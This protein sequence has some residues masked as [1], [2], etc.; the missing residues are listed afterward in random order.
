[1]VSVFPFTGL[2]EEEEVAAEEQTQ[3]ELPLFR[4]YA[5][6]FEKN[7]FYYKDGNPILLEGLDALQIW[8]YKTLKTERF[9]YLAYSW[10][11]GIELEDT[12]LT[13][14]TSTGVDNAE[15]ERYVREALLVN[16]YIT[17]IRDFEAA[18]E[19]AKLLIS[20]VAVTVYGEVEMN[21]GV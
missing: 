18:K 19:S 12:I 2:S 1:M 7:D 13:A 5:W 14:S 6:D 15:A 3:S 17:D 4:E 11:F 8:M 10:D 9:R 16:T 20:F 21:A